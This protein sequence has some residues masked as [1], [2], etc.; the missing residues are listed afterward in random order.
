MRPR[1]ISTFYTKPRWERRKSE[2]EANKVHKGPYEFL[3]M[4][5]WGWYDDA[6]ANP[7]NDVTHRFVRLAHGVQMP[8]DLILKYVAMKIG[9]RWQR[10][11]HVTA[12]STQVRREIAS[13]TTVTLNY[14]LAQRLSILQVKSPSY[15]RQHTAKLIIFLFFFFFFFF[16]TWET[17]L[18]RP[19]S[20]RSLRCK[21]KEYGGGGEL[22]DEKETETL[23]V[24]KYGMT[25]INLTCRRNTRYEDRDFG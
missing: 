8:D 9:E 6:F 7:A 22:H 18:P 12:S 1:L 4:V 14:R 24:E 19:N 10:T 25:L 13:H 21:Q 3:A 23:N 11:H 15:S 17:G 16:C 5:W 20:K 2:F